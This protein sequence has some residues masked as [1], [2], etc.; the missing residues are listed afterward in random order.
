MALG[1]LWQLEDH[2]MALRAQ[3]IGALA[4]H[5]GVLSMATI[6]SGDDGLPHWG[7]SLLRGGTS[8][9][10]TRAWRG[11]LKTLSQEGLAAEKAHGTTLIFT[12]DEEVDFCEQVTPHKQIIAE[13]M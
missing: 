6:R 12:R 1:S 10:S 11:V 8:Q 13:K 5:K 9:V 2:L 7:G 3:T 4:M